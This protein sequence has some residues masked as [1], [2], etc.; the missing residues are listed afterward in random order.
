[1]KSCLRKSALGLIM[2]L[3][4][5]AGAWAESSVWVVKGPK[6]T[7]YL[8]GSCHMLRASD[9]PL[10]AEFAKAYQLSKQI[11]FEAPLAEMGK[12]DYLQ[13]LM[14]AAL[15]QDGSTL[16]DHLSEAVQNKV[17]KFCKARNYECE[18]YQPF[19]PWMFSM[20]LTMLEMARIGVEPSY[21]V[22]HFFNEKAIS[23]GKTIGALETVDEQ[24]GFLTMLDGGMG[25]EH[26]SE[27]ID[28][29]KELDGKMA[30]F[31]S[32]WRTGDEA[33]LEAFTVRELRSY[34]K[35]Y[36]A[37]VV[38]RNKKWTK[39]IEAYLRNS[40]DTMVIVGVAHL[41]GSDSVPNLLRKRGYPVFKLG[42]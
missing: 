4:A 39:D 7:V 37:L 8:A 11:V 41:A 23:D 32:S 13:K 35:L 5:A 29:L 26:V 30:G 27:T 1:M 24:I 3:L 31:L 38:D 21:G 20:M 42:Q 40:T 9:H 12:P 14:A 16:Q 6:V 28:E 15:Y 10:P 36:Q 18:K 17:K 22:D 2:V 19:R 34:P 25:N 33:G